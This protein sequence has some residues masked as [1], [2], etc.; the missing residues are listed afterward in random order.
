MSGEL[1]GLLT[2]LRNR[3]W[4]V[5]LPCSASPLPPIFVR[6]YPWLP[7]EVCEFVSEVSEAYRGDGRFWLSTA[8]DFRGESGAS[9]AWN[10][11]ELLSL[12]AAE[13][14][15][16]RIRDIRGF[17]DKHAPLVLSV[18]DGYAYYAIRQ[19]GRIVFGREPEFEEADMICES[20]FD[21]LLR[22]ANE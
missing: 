22:F 2:L 21:L 8:A 13:G 6:R 18:E 9:Y 19:D 17:W 10:E 14:D 16:D 5:S 7:R 20:F 15:A 12:E 4:Q 1:K 3:G 11:W